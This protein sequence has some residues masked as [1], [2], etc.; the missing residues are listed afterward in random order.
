M[1]HHPSGSR[2]GHPQYTKPLRRKAVGGPNNAP[3]GEVTHNDGALRRD[4]RQV[5]RQTETLKMVDGMRCELR[6]FPGRVVF[7]SMY[8]DIVCGEGGNGELCVANSQ[9]AANYAR[10]SARG[11]WSFLGLGSE[12]EMVRIKHVQAEWRVG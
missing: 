1:S 8:G 4:N 6:Q 12:K 3:Q 11:R 10:R 5:F 7:M 2:Q 9:I